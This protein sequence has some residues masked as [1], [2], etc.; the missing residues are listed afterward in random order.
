MRN[1]FCLAQPSTAEGYGYP[2][3]ESMACG[4]PAVVSDIPVLKETTG[5]KGL[6]A[7]PHEPMSWAEAFQALEK[8]DLRQLK[9]EEGLRWVEP[10]RGRKAWEKHIQ[11]ITALLNLRGAPTGSPERF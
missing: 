11:D 2:P 5:G 9:I 4:V 8:R 7:G 10:L 1:A 3:M 6:F